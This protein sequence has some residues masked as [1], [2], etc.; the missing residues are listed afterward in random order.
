MAFAPFL[1]TAAPGRALRWIDYLRESSH[2][3]PFH[4]LFCLWERK[5]F[6]LASSC[7]LPA[8]VLEDF[9]IRYL[10]AQVSHQQWET[11]LLQYEAYKY[12][13]L[14]SVSLVGLKLKT[15]PFTWKYLL[16]FPLPQ[17]YL[18]KNFE[19]IFFPWYSVNTDSKRDLVSFLFSSLAPAPV[20]LVFS[21]HFY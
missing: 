16:G 17:W 1:K 12:A 14:G 6:S 5:R 3:S 19:S 7:L 9:L 15:P 8:S 18:C 2:T 4:S 20:D 21:C 11:W 10:G 13:S